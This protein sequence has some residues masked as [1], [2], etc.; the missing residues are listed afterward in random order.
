MSDKIPDCKEM[1]TQYSNIYLL[2]KDFCLC[3]HVVQLIYRDMSCIDVIK[4]VAIYQYHSFVD[5]NRVIHQ[6]VIPS[7]IC[8][9][10]L[11]SKYIA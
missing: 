6:Y 11:G 4:V 10:R 8:T 2:F 7:L 5:F 1:L 3:N 9:I